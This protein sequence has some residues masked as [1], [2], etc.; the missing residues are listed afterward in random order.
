[1]MT[2]LK[3]DIEV[4]RAVQNSQ[5]ALDDNSRALQELLECVYGVGTVAKERIARMLPCR[6]NDGTDDPSGL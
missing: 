4:K 1:M 3:N 5:D 2:L 6:G